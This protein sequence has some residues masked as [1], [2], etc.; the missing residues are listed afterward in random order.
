MNQMI[1]AANNFKENICPVVI[2]N[3]W[4]DNFK[5]IILTADLFFLI[6]VYKTKGTSGSGHLEQPLLYKTQLHSIVA[7]Y[8]ED[9]LFIQN[10]D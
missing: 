9:K 4:M 8:T 5:E 3:G 2:E 6:P 7:I 1:S 10:S